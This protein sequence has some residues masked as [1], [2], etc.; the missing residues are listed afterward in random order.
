MT[1]KA[2]IAVIDVGKTNIELWVA[3]K[4][5]T[6]LESR[7]TSNSVLDGQTWRYH[8]LEG[9]SIWLITTL[10]ELCKR[11]PIRTIVPVGH[12][13]GGVLVGSDVDGA[14]AGQALP[15]IDYEQACPADIDAEYRK[16]AGTFED[17]GSPVMMASTHAARQLLWMERIYP[18]EFC[19]ARHFLNIAQFWGWWL[20]GVAASEYSAMGAQSH[21]WN[22]PQRRWTPNVLEQG[23]ETLMPEFKAAWNPLGPVREDLVQ[24]FDLPQD[25]VVLT[26]A[27]DS[28][29]NFFR[30]LAAQVKDFTLVSTGTWVVALSHDVE[31]G[32]LDQSLGTTINADMDGNP[33]GG[34]LTMGGREFSAIAGADTIN[35][36]A[37][38]KVVARLIARGTMAMPSFGDNDGQFPGSARRGHIVGAPPENQAERAALAVLHSA[39]L[40]VTCTDFLDGGSRLILD[41]TFLK[42]P[43]YAQIVAALRPGLRTEASHE[44]HGVVAGALQLACRASGSPSTPLTLEPVVPIVLPGLTEYATQWREAANR[45]GGQSYD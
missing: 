8:D 42:D 23:W 36:V 45:Q 11:H 28:T 2:D 10:A 30:Y 40:T 14:G 6:L 39:L 3:N 1:G 41:G 18:A 26:G 24:R 33:I 31:T 34:A 22:V 17:R 20:T 12:G 4:D 13:S 7:S 35:E 29:A 25:M 37:E 16:K 9:N 32:K 15:M 38:Q 43:M 44:T 21:L 5:G 19:N 27:H